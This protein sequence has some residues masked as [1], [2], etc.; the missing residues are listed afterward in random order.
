MP[1][2][3]LA[4]SSELR[5]QIDQGVPAEEIAASWKEPV[6]RFLKTRQKYLLY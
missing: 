4:G 1:I 3:C 6:E 2:D 5:R